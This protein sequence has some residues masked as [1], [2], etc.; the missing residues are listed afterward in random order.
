LS[1]RHGC[2]SFAHIEEAPLHFIAGGDEPARER[3]LFVD[4]ETT[5]LAGGTG[6]V[7]FLLGLARIADGMLI[8]RQYFLCA[9]RG[10]PAML[11]HALEW[12]TP[13]CRLVSFNGKC[14]D[15]PL[16]AT[17]YQLALRRNPLASLPHIDLLHPARA[18]F[19]RNWPDCRLQTA[20]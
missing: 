16:L 18:A 3:L 5:G 12:L 2:V 20:E 11:D 15:A 6:T 19:R 7:A 13:D 9:F 10:E 8:V 14:F 17:R 1:H 4:T